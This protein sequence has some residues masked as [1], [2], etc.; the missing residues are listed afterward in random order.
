MRTVDVVG[1]SSVALRFL[2]LQNFKHRSFYKIYNTL[3]IDANP[4]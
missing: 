4:N 1:K 3:L 2:L